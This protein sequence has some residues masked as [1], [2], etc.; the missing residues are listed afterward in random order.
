[1]MLNILPTWPTRLVI[2]AI[3]LPRRPPLLA[4]EPLYIVSYLL[5]VT[6]CNG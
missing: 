3:E 1:M 2:G 6:A 5:E 4:L